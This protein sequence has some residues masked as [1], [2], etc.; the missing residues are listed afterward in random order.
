MNKQELIFTL[1]H[2]LGTAKEQIVKFQE[3]LAK[4][5]AHAFQWAEGAMTAAAAIEVYGFLL[6]R[7]EIETVTVGAINTLALQKTM[8][9]A[10]WPAA[11][12]SD[13]SNA[14]E[15]KIGAAWAEVLEI[16]N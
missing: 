5:P 11:S 14:M 8:H 6:G 12:S 2:K 13:V 3:K 9:A 15:R 4:N 7:L 16:L 1:T 10:R